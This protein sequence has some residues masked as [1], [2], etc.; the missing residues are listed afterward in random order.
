MPG[1][2]EQELKGLLDGLQSGGLSYDEAKSRYQ[3][4]GDAIRARYERE[5]TAVSLDV[6]HSS[7]I[8]AGANP[9]DA[10]LAFDA[11]HRWVEQVLAAHGC[12]PNEFTWAGDGLLAI[13][14]QPEPAVAAAR[15]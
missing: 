4:L 13:F 10:Q 1:E 3:Q 7:Q 15:S 11:Y 5:T 14:E 8:K 9:L 12:G 2:N 6:V